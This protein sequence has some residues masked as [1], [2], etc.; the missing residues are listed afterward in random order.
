M[1]TIYFMTWNKWPNCLLGTD[2]K[3]WHFQ[4][5]NA[6]LASSGGCR[7]WRCIDR[8]QVVAGCGGAGAGERELGVKRAAVKDS[9]YP[10]RYNMED[11]C[12]KYSVTIGCSA[13]KP[14]QPIN[15]C[16]RLIPWWY[17]SNLLIWK[18]SRSFLYSELFPLVCSIM[19][20]LKVCQ[21]VPW[22]V[23]MGTGGLI[24]PPVGDVTTVIC[25]TCL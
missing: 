7:R 21:G 18:W 2:I 13:L 11:I 3:V 5:S 12:I 17:V 14:P 10:W 25:Y 23:K 16:C 4:L 1:H 22:H 6:G 15:H 24:H 20:T 8:R 19:L 9:Q